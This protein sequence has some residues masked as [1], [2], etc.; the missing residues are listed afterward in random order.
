M[1][2]S[3]ITIH[4]SNIIQAAENFAYDKALYWVLNNCN[5]SDEDFDKI[6]R[7]MNF[8]CYD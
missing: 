8:P 4:L 6:K 2:L 5:L 3:E 7:E 1:E